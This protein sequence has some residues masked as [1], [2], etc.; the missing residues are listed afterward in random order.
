M[1]RIMTDASEK[2][3]TRFQDS[4]S[5]RPATASTVKTL[6][7]KSENASDYDLVRR[8]IERVSVDYRD[9]PSLCELAR[10]SGSCGSLSA[11]ESVEQRVE[12][13]ALVRRPT[14]P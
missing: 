6:A 1:L 3:E 2:S 13:K 7:P 9:Q 5:Q 8:A 11:L 14:R 12:D 4:A 10:V